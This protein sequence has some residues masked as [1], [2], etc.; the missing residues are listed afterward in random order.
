MTALRT[1]LKLVARLGIG[2]TLLFPAARTTIAA[3]QP[4]VI[5]VMTDDQGYGDLACHGN[6]VIQTPNIDKLHSESVRLTNFHVGPTCSPTRAALLTGRHCNRVQVWHTIM[7]RSLLPTDEVTMAEVFAANGYR[8]GMFGK[9][10][11]GDNYPMRPHDQGFHEALTFGGGAIGNTP[12]YWGNDY[13]GDT[14]YRNGEAEKF[15]GYCTDIWFREGLKFIEKNKDQPFFL[16][17]PTNA[18]HVP[19][20][21]AE[22]YSKAYKDKGVESPLAEFYGMITNIDDNMGRLMRKLDELDLRENTILIFMTDNGSTMGRS[23]FNA[24]MRGQKGSEYEGGHRV[25]FFIRWPGG[26]LQGGRD[27]E[28]VTAHLDVMPTL[29]EMCGLDKPERVTFDGVSL[30]PLL[31]GETS[32]WPQRTLITD[33][34]RV[35]HPIKWRRSSVMTERWRLV[36][37]TE[38]YEIRADPGQEKDVADQQGEVVERLRTAYDA[39]WADLT[40]SFSKYARIVLG[41]DQANPAWLNTHDTHGEVIWL[42][43]HVKQGW[44]S[45]GF[46][47]VDVA[48]SGSYEISLRRWPPE[49][50]RPISDGLARSRRWRP[51]RQPS[52]LEGVSEARLSIGNVD[53]IQP[54]PSDAAEVKF[55]VRLEAGKARLQAWFIHGLGSG[56]TH[57][58]Y[59]VGVERVAAEP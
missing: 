39:W 48:E 11:L 18:P 58:A 4:N 49:V 6:P 24:G 52:V 32:R 34:Q 9:W 21:V 15:Q 45:D 53:V 19:F 40:P 8:T 33:S 57:G 36:N 2:T 22:E 43:D 7:G 37:G 12:D 23:A 59:Y 54:V 25:P 14:Y 41:A 38:L 27:V 13:F 55:N 28:N 50:D 56:A 17:L 20:F 1:H 42:H 44:R 35:D 46:W 5:L 3:E 29:I 16:Y 47:A 10:H 30:V 31:G 26:K 51:G